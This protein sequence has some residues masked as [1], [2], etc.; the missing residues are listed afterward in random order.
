MTITGF[1]QGDLAPPPSELT[2]D[3]VSWLVAGVALFL[4]LAL[5][6]GFGGHRPDRRNHGG[7]EEI[8]R[9]L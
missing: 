7:V 9:L 6:C 3:L 4:A 2:Y 1:R 5:L 8:G